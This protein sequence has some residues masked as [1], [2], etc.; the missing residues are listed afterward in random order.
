MQKGFIQV[1]I[2]LVILI[3]ATIVGGGGY[4]AAKEISKS[5]IIEVEQDQLDVATLIGSVDTATST[6]ESGNIKLPED[7]NDERSSETSGQHAISRTIHDQEQEKREVEILPQ[8]D[9]EEA[10]DKR[11][12]TPKPVVEK[13]RL[14]ESE[15]NNVEEVDRHSEEETIAN[16][17][18]ATSATTTA[19]IQYVVRPGD[20]LPQ[21]AQMF[22]VSVESI[23][24]TNNL[25]NSAVESGTTIKIVTVTDE[26]SAIVN[27]DPSSTYHFYKVRH[28]DTLP[29][30]AQMFGVSVES[31]LVTN[32][33]S[34]S[35]V[36]PGITLKI[37][38]N[39]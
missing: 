3:G 28:G 7:I 6:E 39:N 2:L 34:D 31:I 30:I 20:T 1:P 29:Q 14:L 23:L 16:E 10:P 12:A 27:T 19:M 35:S 18:A 33:L 26:E 22:G 8:Q 4:F 5:K 37:M 32:N 21:I 9:E 13:R 36:E 25:K 15:S 11:L 24:D 17:E 38:I